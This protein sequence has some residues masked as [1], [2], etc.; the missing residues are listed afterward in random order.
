MTINVADSIFV[1]KASSLDP[2]TCSTTGLSWTSGQYIYVIWGN[3]SG[4]NLATP[5][6]NPILGDGADPN[7][8]TATPKATITNSNARLHVHEYTV[9]GTLDANIVVDLASATRGVLGAITIDQ[10][11]GPDGNASNFVS[12]VGT[13]E[14]AS[15]PTTGFPSC[16]GFTCN[17]AGSLIIAVMN[18]IGAALTNPP[19]K[20]SGYT[21]IGLEASST[22][23][24]TNTTFNTIAIAVRDTL[25]SAGE[26]VPAATWGGL[27]DSGNRPWSTVHFALKPGVVTV[28]G[29]LAVTDAVDAL[30]AAGEVL[31]Y[32]LLVPDAIIASTNLSGSVADIDE[33]I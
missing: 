19:V 4:I 33:V 10:T 13:L 1:R 9:V 21:L 2:Q 27:S 28:A 5:P 22:N 16:S 30:A 14:N 18:V 7:K 23:A 17:T 29:T 31:T 11:A 3:S 24:P 12:N 25:S 20:P 26:S 6:P 32:A 8:D 15:P